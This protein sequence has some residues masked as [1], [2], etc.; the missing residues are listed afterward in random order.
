M[1]PVRAD[2]LL[3]RNI[4]KVPGLGVIA[5]TTVVTRH[6]PVGVFDSG[7]GGLSV[8]R[9]I[10]RELPAEDLLYVADSGYAPYGDQTTAFIQERAL[11]LVEFLQSQDSK[12]VVVA[13]NTATGIAVEAL[14]SHF[15]LPIIAIEP[16][17]KPAAS[18][19][20]SG[21]VGVLATTQT[22][23]SQRF[24]SL[25][26]RHAAEVQVFEQPCPGL[27]EQVEAGEF[28]SAATRSLVEQYVRPLLEKG[29][30]TIV[31]GCTHYPFLSEVIQDIAGPDVTVI[32]PAVAVARELRRRLQVTGLLSP[33]TN[34]GTER[35]WTTGP[36]ER[37]LT[38]IAQ[39][40][41]AD[42]EVRG[43]P[44]TG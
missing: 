1:L 7:V 4:A 32:D 41:K 26:R 29:A 14:R 20:R 2:A 16:A 13:C 39:L 10:R 5:N 22:L 44:T 25:V 11:A 28:G 38:V 30:D 36:P 40:W 34:Q 42:V 19:T 15:S 33:P 23:S 31:L 6:A 8:L 17:I 24:S 37:A 35:F 12:A 9:E 3:I 43:L 27:V 18:R 21:K